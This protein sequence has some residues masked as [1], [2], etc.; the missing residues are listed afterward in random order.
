MSLKS[1]STAKL[2]NIYHLTIYYLQFIL[3]LAVLLYCY[4]ALCIICYQLFTKQTSFCV[5]LLM[6]HSSY[7]SY[8]SYKS[9]ESYEPHE[10]YRPHRPY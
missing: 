7:K 5:I 1:K 8:R 2:Q 3:N 4:H 9:H 6:G 10:S